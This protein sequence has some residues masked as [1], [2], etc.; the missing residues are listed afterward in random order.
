MAA[1]IAQARQAE[2]EARHA[3]ARTW[4]EAGEQ[5]RRQTVEDQERVKRR[6]L[7]ARAQLERAEMDEEVYEAKDRG[8]RERVQQEEE[9]ATGL[10]RP[11]QRGP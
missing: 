2:R 10:Y 1:A 7:E 4:A 8:A 9:R 11:W 3:R 5:A 6:T